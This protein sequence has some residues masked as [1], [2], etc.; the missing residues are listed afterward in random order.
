VDSGEFNAAK[1]EVKVEV[2][3]VGVLVVVD[4]GGQE[5]QEDAEEDSEK[6]VEDEME[7]KDEVEVE[8]E[9]EEEVDA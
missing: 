7:V 3:V 9:V 6:E 1:E 2:T 8:V 5:R 4:S